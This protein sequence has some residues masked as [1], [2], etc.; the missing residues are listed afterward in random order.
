MDADS[1]QAGIE[2]ADKLIGAVARMVSEWEEGDEQA[3]AFARRLTSFVLQR[4]GQTPESNGKP[5][6]SGN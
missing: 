4:S 2:I 6:S 1:R 5:S 3:M